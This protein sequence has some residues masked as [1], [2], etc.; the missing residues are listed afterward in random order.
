MLARAGARLIIIL[1]LELYIHLPSLYPDQPGSPLRWELKLLWLLCPRLYSCVLSSVC[2]L[3]SQ[4]TLMW[5]ILECPLDSLCLLLNF[6]MPFR[7]PC[8]MLVAHVASSLSLALLPCV[9]LFLSFIIDS[10]C[11]WD[12]DCW[13][14]VYV[15]HR[16]ANRATF[17]V[18][19]RYYVHVPF[20]QKWQT[21]PPSGLVSSILLLDL[22][23]LCE[24]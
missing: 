12:L 17:A 3:S 15:V 18:F 16:L 19:P 6:I 11:L 2:S 1:N 14:M 20:Q 5:L 13:C 7:H 24:F 23:P 9:F 8:S 10:V 4:S 21:L 22:S